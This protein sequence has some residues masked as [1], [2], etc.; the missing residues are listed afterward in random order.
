MRLYDKC[1]SQV[2]QILTV[3]IWVSSF[4]LELLLCMYKG[5]QCISLHFPLDFQLEKARVGDT[6]CIALNCSCTKNGL[7]PPSP[8]NTCSVFPNPDRLQHRCLYYLLILVV[9]KKLEY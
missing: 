5:R 6:L 3:S 8:S 2:I 1:K 4:V 9:G 7:Y